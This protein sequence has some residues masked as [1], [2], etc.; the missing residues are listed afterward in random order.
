MVCIAELTLTLG[1]GDGCPENGK[2]LEGGNKEEHDQTYMY[3]PEEFDRK[4]RSVRCE[5]WT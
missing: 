5:M 2:K 4:V 3:L 1:R